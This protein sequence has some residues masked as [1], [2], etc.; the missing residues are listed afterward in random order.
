MTLHPIKRLNYMLPGRGGTKVRNTDYLNRMIAHEGRKELRL[1][2]E[3]EFVDWNI[4]QLGNL[5]NRLEVKN[6]VKHGKV[7]RKKLRLV[8]AKKAIWKDYLDDL[9]YLSYE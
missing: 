5:R 9:D 4:D 3:I 8:T 2:Q 7:L 1:Q 6:E